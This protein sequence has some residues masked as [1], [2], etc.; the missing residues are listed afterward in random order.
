MRNTS[1]MIDDTNDL[2][3][4]WFTIPHS[5]VPLFTQNSLTTCLKVVDT[6]LSPIN[7]KK[8]KKKRVVDES[9]SL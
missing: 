6:I 4:S 2:K 8:N 1:N 5:F 7:Q 3:I 9:Y